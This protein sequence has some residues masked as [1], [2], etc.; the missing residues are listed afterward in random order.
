M[1]KIIIGLTLLSSISAHAD[2][3]RCSKSLLGATYRA[4]VTFL[5]GGASISISSSNNRATRNGRQSEGPVTNQVFGAISQ[6][7]IN[8][9]NVIAMDLPVSD[10]HTGE[11]QLTYAEI[12]QSGTEHSLLVKGDALPLFNQIKFQDCKRI[13]E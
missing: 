5:D 13:V 9:V 11:P 1:K 12:N 10:S 3:I 4:T 6:Q 2:G 8:N 7:F